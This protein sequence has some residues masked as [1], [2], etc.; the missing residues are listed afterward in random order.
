MSAPAGPLA[1]RSVVPLLEDGLAAAL[2]LLVVHLVPQVQEVLA[3][4]PVAMEAFHQAEQEVALEL[5][6]ELHLSVP[7]PLVDWDTSAPALLVKL[8][9]SAPVPIM[10]QETMALAL[11]ADF[12]PSALGQQSAV[13][14]QVV[15]LEPPVRPRE[16]YLEYLALDL[17]QH[18][19]AAT[20]L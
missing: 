12:R 15:C 3:L 5:A 6:L 9:A 20:L 14:D 8:A 19:E 18:P 1:L 16:V 17:E 4:A 10:D 7:M 13:P 2:G 11:E